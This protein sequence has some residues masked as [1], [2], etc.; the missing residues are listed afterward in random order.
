MPR[1]RILL[2]AVACLAL[3]TQATFAEPL[4]SDPALVTGQLDNGLRYIVRKH[5]NPPGRAVVWIH[6]NTGSLNETDPQRGIAHYLEHMAFNGS[7]NFKPGELVPFFQSLGMQFGRDQNAFTSL[8]QTVYQ[9]TLPNV[10]PETLGKAFTFFADVVHRLDLSPG[11][12]EEE[13]QIIQEERRTRLG[14]RQRVSEYINERLYPG[15]LLGVRSPIGTEATINS[16]QPAD[17]REFYGKW[18]GA[19]NATLMV[20]ADADTDAVVKQIEQYFGDAP[21]KP[22]ATPQDAGVKPYSQSFAIVASDAE[23]R[24]EDLQIVRVEPARPPT[25]TVD[26]FRDEL[27]AGLGSAIMN[28][29]FSDKVAAGG[30]PYLSARVGTSN[31]N[32]VVYSASLNARASR[33][34]WNKALDGAALELQRAR[35]FGFTQT[36]LDDQKKEIISSAE[37][38]V[39]T[40]PTSTQGALVARINAGVNSEE[41]ILSAA[42]RLELLQRVLPTITPQEVSER[43]AREFDF[44]TAAFV[45]TLPAAGELPSES[46]LLAAGVK[47]LSVEPTKEAEIARATT[48]LEKAP[49]PGTVVELSEHPAS[50][51]WSGWLSNNVRVHYRF[52]DDRKDEVSIAINL[53]GGELF[54]TAE[55]RGITTAAQLAWGRA[56]T[57]KLS[58]TDIRN[59]MSGK[60]VRVGGGGGM[61]MGGRG[62]RGGGGGGAREALSLG[63]NGAPADL[64]PGFQLAYLLLTDPK[65]EPA[66]FEQFKTVSREALQEAMKNPAAAGAR[67]AASAPYPDNEPR[68]KPLEIEDIDRLDLATA[69][70]WLNKLIAE[71]PIE[72]TI[73]GDIEKDQ[74]MDLVA[75]YLG[76]LPTRPRVETGMF[77]ELRKLQRPTGPRVIEQTIETPT[78][79]AFV[80][81]GFYGPDETNRPDVRAMSVA[82]RILSTRMVKQVREEAQLVYSIGAGARPGSTF[83]GF[84]VVSAAAPTDPSKV[85]GLVTKLA[86]MYETFA[87][88]GPTEDELAV[89]KKQFANTFEQQLKEPGYWS[90]RMNL[91]TY[92]GM[93]L[94][95]AVSDPEAYQAITAEQV[96]E[97]FGKYWSKDNSI[98]VIVR[99]KPVT[100][101][102]NGSTEKTG[103]TE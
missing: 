42:Q 28:R 11:E 74:V 30:A 68:V 25:T 40:E 10:E 16:V 94:D 102:A 53:L 93:S 52:M 73:V 98:V 48:L 86:E 96:K 38:A 36:E 69:Q 62:G 58:S 82:T 23:I 32:G 14:G 61:M 55:N 27:V 84:G 29:R 91:L 15:S 9:L 89:A 47:A 54:E 71:S 60:K 66:A 3:L 95:D 81:S 18:Y 8:D 85:E 88:E 80:L 78:Q 87:Q 31:L 22:R 37:W 26:Q 41:P 17:F 20:V 64:E 77:A 1:S 75:R 70:A 46:D 13:R 43:F 12:I 19:S 97:T 103:A 99:P 4:P 49:V 33:G 39:S 79:Q 24:S 35:K 92:R 5:G 63:I 65:I 57:S 50:K 45:A 51:V 67:L 90:G 44:T 100:T 72:V 34:N 76:A 2:T 6:I 21:A 59:L 83:P 7:A 101:S 56:A